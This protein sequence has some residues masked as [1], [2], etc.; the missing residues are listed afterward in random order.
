MIKVVIM[1]VALLLGFG[2]PVFAKIY[3]IPAELKADVALS[4]QQYKQNP[5]SADTI[6]ELS[7]AYAYTGQIE[8][9]W[10]LLKSIPKYDKDYSSKVIKKYEPLT[11]SQP[12]EWRNHFKLAFGYYFAGN[13]DAAVESF[14]KVLDIDPKHVWAMGFLGLVEG[15]RGNTDKGMEWSKKALAIEPNA[16]A[17]HFLIA[18]GYR[19]KGDYM[20]AFSHLMM[21][22]RLKSEEALTRKK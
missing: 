17:I 22:G 20:K 21:V 14:K 11:K 12:Q 3:Q 7:M 4:E 13:K 19:R 18:E 1:A 8:K 6:F 10:E 15:E 9:G 2:H 16:T 5:N